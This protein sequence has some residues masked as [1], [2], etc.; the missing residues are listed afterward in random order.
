[1]LRLLSVFSITMVSLL[2]FTCESEEEVEKNVV[3]IARYPDNKRAAISFTFDD[4][5][6]SCI[7]TIAPMFK[8]YGYRATFFVIPGHI[9]N[10]QWYDWKNLSDNGFEI[11]NH[12]LAHFNLTALEPDILSEHVNHAHELITKNIGEAPISFAEPGHRTNEQVQNAL[13]EKH[14][15][16]RLSPSLCSWH[17]WTSSTTKKDAI[18]HIN[19][20]IKKGSWYVPAAHGVDDCWEPLTRDFLIG[21]LDHIAQH[22]GQLAVETFGHLALYKTEYENT[23]LKHEETEGSITLELITNLDTTRY[24]YPLT[25]V[26]RNCSF[27]SH[28][29]VTPLNSIPVEFIKMGETLLLKAKPGAKF[30]I[31]W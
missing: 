15:F 26:V 3:S 13:A 24:N 29:S 16:T 22:E 25:I 19:E 27:S 30:E 6:A 12:S 23:A 18:S 5:C 20:A 11:A 2:C 10:D 4:G 31:T 9:A 7:T 14:L 28:F 1:M 21:V 8:D 17:G